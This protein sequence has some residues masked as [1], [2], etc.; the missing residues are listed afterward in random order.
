MARLQF[1]GYGRRMN[2]PREIDDLEDDEDDGPLRWVKTPIE[3]STYAADVAR[4]NTLRIHFG[5][6]SSESLAEVVVVEGWETVSVTLINRLLTGTY[7]DG[8][9]TGIKMDLRHSCVELDLDAPLAARNV[10]DGSTGRTGSPLAPEDV[11]PAE[12]CPRWL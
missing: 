12:P 1:A 5:H 7:P 4:E 3:W 8:T 6:S 2:G 9:M 10:I 11:N